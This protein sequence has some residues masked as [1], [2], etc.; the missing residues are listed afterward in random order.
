M[1]KKILCLPV[2]YD[3]SEGL[4]SEDTLKE[5]NKTL[6]VL[7]K[8]AYAN[9]EDM[10]EEDWKQKRRK[11]IGGSDVSGI[12]G[13]SPFTNNIR[14]WLDKTELEPNDLSE[15]WFRLD[16]G[17]ALEPLVAK[18]FAKELKAIC[19]NDKGMYRHSKYEFALANLDR[20]V[21]LPTGE[22]AILE[23]KTTNAFAKSEWE[24]DAP[25]HYRWQGQHYLA[26]INSI[27]EEN[28]CP[29]IN[30]VYYSAVYGNTENDVIYKKVIRQKI[31]EEKML[32]AEKNFWNC[33]T[34]MTMPVF[35]GSNKEL[36]ELNIAERIVLAKQNNTYNP[37]DKVVLDS[38]ATS[39]LISKYIDIEEKEKSIKGELKDIAEAK[40][41]IAA[42]LVS[43]MQGQDKVDALVG[44]TKYRLSLT[45]KRSRSTD[46]NL[47]KEMYPQVYDL[48]IKDSQSAPSFK[49]AKEREKTKK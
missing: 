46:Y 8:C 21:I 14:I 29:P 37:N 25:V 12:M 39:E 40:A 35:N 7:K 28:D 45:S 16:Y 34:T 5:I 42:V 48:T 17:H 31:I 15:N 10:S 33:V 2:E 38:P 22:L 1:D 11:G 36:L 43:M 23:C 20:L 47:L 26:V 13:D 32:E 27:L 30:K 4:I 6:M 44:D 3:Y 49:I 24:E 19:I 41:G 9:S 18:M